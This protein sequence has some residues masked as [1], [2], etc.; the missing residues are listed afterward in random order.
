MW[1]VLQSGG[2]GGSTVRILIL[3]FD[4]DAAALLVW[5]SHSCSL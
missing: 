3:G 4:G 5:L 2:T 1:D